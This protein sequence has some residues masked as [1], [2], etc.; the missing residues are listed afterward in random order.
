MKYCGDDIYSR[1]NHFQILKISLFLLCGTFATAVSAQTC[2]D[3]GGS[4]PS[5]SFQNFDALL[6]SA[7][8]ANS[9]SSN[10]VVL[11]AAAPRRYLGKFDNSINDS[12][13]TVNIPG[14]AL[15][16]EGTN[17]GSVTG[18]YNTGDGSAAG[19]N[20]YTYGNSSD[21]ALGSLNDTTQAV[22]YLGACFVNAGTL[23]YTVAVSYSGE[24]W[25][26][27]ASGSQTDRLDFQ[28]SKMASAT[29]S[30]IYDG[31]GTWTDD[32]A[33]DLVSPNTS[34]AVGAL[35]GNAA[36]NTRFLS[37]NNVTTIAPGQKIYIRWVDNDIAAADD[38][39]AIDDVT[40]A[41]T[42]APTAAAASVS[43]QVLDVSGRGL[44][45]A[46]V[47]LSDNLSRGLTVTTNPFGY[48]TFTDVRAGQNYVISVSAKNRVFQNPTRIISVEDAI[49]DIIFRADQ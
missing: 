13:E 49:T 6:T 48:F 42:A 25:R 4:Y 29:A 24:Q 1:M 27:G 18:R 40:V 28:Y 15:V 34:A 32:D 19:A 26:R 3:L 33:L 21:R 30:N 5:A 20:T 12:G 43:G 23:T 31:S 17:S 45:G 14:W 7:G 22:N 44:S 47:T 11:N 35:D 9:N 2:I 46:R 38:A 36:A 39:L 37:K 16:E 10:I 8:P 41:F